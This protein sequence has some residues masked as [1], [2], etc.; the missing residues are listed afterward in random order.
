MTGWLLGGVVEEDVGELVREGLD[1]LGVVDAGAD[2][3]GAGEEVGPA[4]RGAAGA[5]GWTVPALVDSG[6]GR[7]LADVFVP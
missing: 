6:S 1:G 4:L 7:D 5:A 2:G 3:D